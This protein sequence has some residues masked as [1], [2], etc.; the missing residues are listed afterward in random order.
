M[1]HTTHGDGTI[2]FGAITPDNAD[3]IA[4]KAIADS[5]EQTPY[6]NGALVNASDALQKLS[7]IGTKNDAMA[8]RLAKMILFVQDALA[9][10][11]IRR[12]TFNAA[13]AKKDEDGNIVVR[14]VGSG[15]SQAQVPV[16][17]NDVEFQLRINRLLR[18]PAQTKI[19]PPEPFTW[20]DLNIKFMKKP[21]PA[22]IAQLGPFA[23]LDE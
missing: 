3:A 4:N 2:P 15:D 18:E 7:K 22:M 21:E 9:A 16:M 5:V 13:Y 11:F 12:D 19:E 10:F 23:K 1:T 8:K 20:D 6:T 17:E 14:T